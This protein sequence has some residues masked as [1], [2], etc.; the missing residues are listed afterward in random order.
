MEPQ[1]IEHIV[2]KKLY[3]KRSILDNH[4]FFVDIFTKIWHFIKTNWIGIA[5]VLFIVSLMIF[6]YFEKQKNKFNNSTIDYE[7]VPEKNQ[8]YGGYET[9]YYKM[10]PRVMPPPP[11]N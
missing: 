7:D 6:F 10:I 2:L 9:E 5:V 1:L 3:K 11:E 8:L 4:S